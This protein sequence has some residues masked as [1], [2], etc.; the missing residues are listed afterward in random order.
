MNTIHKLWDILINN[1]EYSNVLTIGFILTVFL[2]IFSLIVIRLLLLYAP[3]NYQTK[4]NGSE[5]IKN[6]VP[7]KDNNDRKLIEALRFDN[8]DMFLN[9]DSLTSRGENAKELYYII[10]TFFKEKEN[11][12]TNMMNDNFFTV[13]TSYLNAKTSKNGNELI[14]YTQSSYFTV[15][16][17][18][19]NIINNIDDLNGYINNGFV[20]SKEAFFEYL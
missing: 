16:K 20:L 1:N 9:D 4:K 5:V 11:I 18:E 2:F 6:K 15:P 7:K 19:L 8:Y 10:K 14:I 13:H 17:S 12:Y 3:Q